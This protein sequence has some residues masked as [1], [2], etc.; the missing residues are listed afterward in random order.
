VTFAPKTAVRTVSDVN[1]FLTR[2][3]LFHTS[4]PRVPM[5]ISHCWINTE[6]EREKLLRDDWKHKEIGDVVR[7]EEPG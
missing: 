6:L 7:P 4:V 3:R 2:H 1:V 5:S